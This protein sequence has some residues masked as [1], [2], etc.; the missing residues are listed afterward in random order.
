[1]AVKAEEEPA[2]AASAVAEDLSRMDVNTHVQGKLSY[3][4]KRVDL[5]E[6]YKERSDSEVGSAG[7]T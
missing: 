7:R 6:K 4:S 3:F 2:P 1:M 5:F